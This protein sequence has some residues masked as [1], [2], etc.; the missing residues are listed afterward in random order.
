ML[1]NRSLRI[2]R[3][4]DPVEDSGD[5]KTGKQVVV[6][7]TDTAIAFFSVALPLHAGVVTHVTSG[8]V[9][10]APGTERILSIGGA[11]WKLIARGKVEGSG[12]DTSVHDYELAITDGHSTQVLVKHPYLDDAVPLLKFAGDLDGDGKL[13]LLI[14][15]THH[16]NLSEPTLLLSSQAKDGELVHNVASFRTTGC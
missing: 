12:P 10:L 7:G 14:D 11:E 8:D 5:E 13:D 3:V 16:Y 15:T 2:E 9:E 1:V 6:D 4:E